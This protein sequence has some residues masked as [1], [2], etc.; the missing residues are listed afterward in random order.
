M[1]RLYA[2]VP[3]A[4]DSAAIGRL[5]EHAAIPLKTVIVKTEGSDYPGLARNEFF[6]MSVVKEADFDV[7]DFWLS[8][9]GLL[10]VM[11]RFDRTP[12]GIALGFEDMAVLTGRQGIGTST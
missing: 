11:S 5:A 3:I 2:L 7:P 1:D 8:D 9:D 12:E 6:C 10:F 4:N